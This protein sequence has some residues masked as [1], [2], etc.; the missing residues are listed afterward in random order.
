MAK[1]KRLKEIA[2][3]T[4]V[5]FHHDDPKFIWPYVPRAASR[6]L[7]HT[8][9]SMGLKLER[10]DELPDINIDDYFIWSFVRSPYTKVISAMS[11]F[12][13]TWDQFIKKNHLYITEGLQEEPGRVGKHMI[14]STFFTHIDGV[15]FIEFIG[16]Y[17]TLDDDWARLLKKLG[18]P[19][20][21]LVIN[22]WS[23]KKILSRVKLDSRAVGAIQ[24]M[25]LEDFM[26]LGYGYD[27]TI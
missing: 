22:K 12:Q 17:E 7:T 11:Y 27:P 26:L 8:F 6:C 2:R 16:Y 1:V 4:G 14:P 3:I 15:P 9:E 5:V 23:T 13:V 21:P 20:T 25:Y 19:Y 10:L 24:D 18:L